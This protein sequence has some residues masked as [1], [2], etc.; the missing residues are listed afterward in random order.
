MPTI[1][2]P[3]TPPAQ[4]DPPGPT[5]PAV[6]PELRAFFKRQ[7]W[8]RGI[9]LGVVAIVGVAFASVSASG[10]EPE[11]I[12][13]T[14]QTVDPPVEEFTEAADGGSVEIVEYGFTPVKD[15]A[16]DDQISWGV[17]VENTS[18]DSVAIA[19]V[20]LAVKGEDGSSL[21]EG[22]GWDVD[23]MTPLLA[24]G[25]RV[26][27]GSTSYIDDGEVADAKPTISAERWWLAADQPTAADA[28]DVSELTS[29]WVG[30][31]D[32]V[33]YWG[34]DGIGSFVDTDGT[35]RLRFR[36][37]V[38][39]EAIHSP[40]AVAIFRNED[41]DIIGANRPDE[42]GSSTTIPHGWSYQE[43]NVKYGPPPN[44]DADSIEI[45]VFA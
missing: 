15:V 37:E 39:G 4:A 31:G 28:V 24:P 12:D 2:T 34:S 14:E 33:P 40:R 29:D 1:D 25:E 32:E 20:A 3:E 19:T 11:T 18:A 7:Y 16:G 44:T 30:A 10:D 38:E 8:T 35:L 13:E 43:I 26:G 9:A 45:Y 17:I 42:I 36:V 6:T 22:T 23:V 41:G 5:A 27:I 21:T